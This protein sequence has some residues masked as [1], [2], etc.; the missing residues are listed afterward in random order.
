MIFLTNIFGCD[1]TKNSEPSKDSIFADV[2][3]K[4]VS[5]KTTAQFTFY[6]DISEIVNG[7]EIKGFGKSPVV[8]DFPKING[9]EIKQVESK[10]VSKIYSAEIEGVEKDYTITF[11]RKDGEYQ[12]VININSNDLSK[13]IRTEFERKMSGKK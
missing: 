11:S 7:K 3:V 5:E 4:K 9:A 2:M 1:G 6:R 10:D 13:P 8:V 12:S